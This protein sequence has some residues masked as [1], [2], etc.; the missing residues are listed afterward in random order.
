MSII[1]GILKADGDSAV[2]PELR[3]LGI[4]TKRHALD[5]TFVKACGRVGMCFQPYLTHQ[6]LGLESQPLGDVMGNLITFDGRLDNYEELCGLL[7][8]GNGERSDSEIALASFQRWGEECFSRFVGDWAVALWSERQRSLYLARDHAGTRTLYYEMSGGVVLWSTY[9]ETFIAYRPNRDLDEAF[10]ACYLVCEPLRDLTPYK[11]IRAVTPGHFVV[12]REDSLRGI[13]P[14]W[15][16]MVRNKFIY[17]RDAEYDEHFRWLFMNAV[18]RRSGPGRS[19]LAQLSGGMD[20]TAIVCMSDQIRLGLGASAEE[21]IDTVSY[22]DDSEP[23]WNEM[24]YFSLVE[25]ARG[26][27]GI[28]I[29]TSAL[30]RSFQPPPAGYFFP[31]AESR[32]AFAEGAVEDCI[33]RGKYRAILSG[34]G[35]DELLG[36]PPNAVPELADYLVSCRAE[37]FCRQSFRWCLEQRTPLIHMIAKTA[38]FSAGIYP[39]MPATRKKLPPWISGRL[40]AQYFA[41][42]K[43]EARPLSLGLL[44]TS[45]DS[46]VTWWKLLETLPHRVQALTVRYE[47]RYPYLDRDLVDFLLRVPAGQLL[48]PGRRRLMMRR[49]LRGIVPAEILERR[50]KAY[51]SRGP[52]MLIP[53]NRDAIAQLFATAL[54]GDYGFIQVQQF[55]TALGQVGAGSTS[56]WLPSMVRAINLELWLRTAEAKSKAA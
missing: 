5:G 21:L 47:F 26:K 56:E 33:G 45:I 16:W 14:H 54:S 8:L 13:K 10:I 12:I 32:T 11:D 6:R 7:D 48:K 51:V 38:R 36:G 20:S 53:Q 23:N 1:F 43:T 30:E 27:R 40:Q 39:R 29:R 37:R 18:E 22:Y 55:R 9:L 41:L 2:E 42:K 3:Q 24:P 52:L 4:A 46:A 50:R 19:V 25:E 44:P 31:G 17:K 35:G 34:I 15:Q 49:A 28:H